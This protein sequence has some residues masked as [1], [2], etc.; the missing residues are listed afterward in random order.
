MGF[1]SPLSDRQAI[2]DLFAAIFLKVGYFDAPFATILVTLTTAFFVASMGMLIGT[3]A[4]KE[5]QVIMFSLIPMF[6]LSGLGGD[7][8]PLEFTSPAFQTIGH[9]TPV[10]W[11]MDGF[12]NIIMRGMGLESVLLPAVVL[13]GFS[14]ACFGIAVWRFEYE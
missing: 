10:A 8:V 13:L 9:F 1:D 12:Q 2:G 11:A 4:K 7:W 3:L 5:E 6:I 14:A